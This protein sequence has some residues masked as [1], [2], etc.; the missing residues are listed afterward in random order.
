MKIFLSKNVVFEKPKAIHGYESEI[1]CVY[2]RKT[3]LYFFARE[4]DYN[5]LKKFK[6]GVDERKI[7]EI[8]T[9]S[10]LINFIPNLIRD[11]FLIGDAY[12]SRE[13][14]IYANFYPRL[15]SFTVFHDKGN[16]IELAVYRFTKHGNVDFDVFEIKDEEAKVFRYFNGS[17]S[18]KDIEK[19]FNFGIEKMLNFVFKLADKDMQIIRLLPMPLSA[20]SA[21]IP[22]LSSPAPVFKEKEEKFELKEGVKEY[23]LKGIKDAAV[24]FE[25]KEST[26][27][28][29]YRVKHPALGNKSYGEALFSKIRKNIKDGARIL[30]IGAGLGYFSKD[31]L[32]CIKRE[33]ISAG[34]FIC[35]LSPELIRSQRE[36]HKKSDVKAF[37]VLADAERMPFKENSFDIIISNEVIAD[38][39][40]PLFKNYDEARKELDKHGIAI[41]KE[42]ESMIKARKN[43]RLNLGAMILIKEVSNLLKEN[44][45]ALISEYGYEYE[46]PRR[47]EHLDHEEYTITFSHLLSVARAFGISAMLANAFDFLNFDNNV[48]ILS[49]D[50]FKALFRILE[51]NNV[52]LPNIAYTRL[53]LL[54]QL[55]GEEVK[56]KNIKNLR[57][58][59][60]SR[61]PI[62]IVKFLILKK[63]DSNSAQIPKTSRIE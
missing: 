23:H 13:N 38:F 8:E 50:S 16:V 42:I 31:F 24:Q 32:L 61:E 47:A 30:E 53:L 39:S 33:K 26:L 57:F 49:S 62:E 9:S 59:K 10:H 17:Y 51:K 45:V 54:N 58:V 18:V 2:N 25:Q 36:I 28:H 27:S 37:Y 29:L 56:L 15:T 46:L 7:S 11:G 43:F 41:T 35:D 60:I 52:Y 63:L 3:G 1:K 20:Y 34:Y 44:G 5:F 22:P 21:E 12:R 6:K 55:K 4:E 40:T 19:A 48:E 14:L